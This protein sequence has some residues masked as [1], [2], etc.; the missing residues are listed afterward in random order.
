MVT[1]KKLS[2]ERVGIATGWPL[3]N[4]IVNEYCVNVIFER[5]T[6]YNNAIMDE[7]NKND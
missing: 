6:V 3:S 5:R 7:S 1:H 2:K 4:K